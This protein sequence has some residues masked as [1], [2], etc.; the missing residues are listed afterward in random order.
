M[1][2]HFFFDISV[3]ILVSAFFAWGSVL[4]RQPVVLAYILAGIVLGPWGL[5]LIPRVGFI[6]QV[7][8]IG[9]SLLL[10]LAGL[11]LHPRRLLQLFR[12][13]ALPTLGTAVVFCLI[14]AEVTYLLGFSV[15]D[16]VVVGAAM[17]FSST[18]LVVKLL[19][20]TTLHQKRL[21]SVCIAVLILQDIL[22]VFAILLVR[23][24]GNGTAMGWVRALFFG[25]LLTTGAIM[26]ERYIL[27]S[28]MKQVEYYQEVLFLLTLGWCF[29]IAIAADAIGL[30][31]E[32][33]AFI[34]GVS[35]A[36]SPISRFL[37][38]GLRFF[39]DFFLVLFFFTLGARIDLPVLEEILLPAALIAAILLIAKPVAY[40][41]SFKIAGESTHFSR[42]M[43]IR[44]GQ[45]SEFALILSIFA[46]MSGTIT[47]SA[48]QLIQLVT[49]LTMLVSSYAVTLMYPTPL[50]FGAVL[51]R[52]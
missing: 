3:L 12:I 51:K 11:N 18:I 4:A 43:G 45:T 24:G 16:S 9:V 5:R 14:S 13:T 40:Y 50:S 28:M 37:S 49:I 42:E 36:N 33:G 2:E 19:P 10:F 25:A 22:A 23:E 46:D 48:A 7:S 17:M 38:E 27:R 39:R 52:D 35:L 29:G 8:H 21:G 31:N 34:A 47:E 41:L 32:I 26:F 1:Q 6:D 15:V 30:S 20:T 44:L